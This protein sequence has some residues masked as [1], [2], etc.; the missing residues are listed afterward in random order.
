MGVTVLRLRSFT[1][2]SLHF[3]QGLF[4]DTIRRGLFA[5]II[6]KISLSYA[7]IFDTVKRLITNSRS[8]HFGQSFRIPNIHEEYGRHMPFIRLEHQLSF[9]CTFTFQYTQPLLIG[10]SQFAGTFY[11]EL[12]GVFVGKALT[13]FHIHKVIHISRASRSTTFFNCRLL[14]A[15]IHTSKFDIVS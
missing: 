4:A 7:V 2:A 10:S 13:I 5:Y 15:N 3:C 12:L 14:R 6:H 1:N 9:Y 8:T 11:S